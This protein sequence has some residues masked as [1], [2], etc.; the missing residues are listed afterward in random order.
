MNVIKPARLRHGD[1]IGVVAPSG[2]V[3][4]ERIDRALGRLRDRGFRTKTYGD[5]YRADG[6]L[7]GDD[8]IRAHELMEAFTDPETTAVWCAR[9]GYGVARIIDQIDFD[10]IRGHPKVFIGFSDISILHIAIAQQTGLCTFHAPNL[11]DG[12]GADD[13]MLPATE[14]ALWH[15]VMVRENAAEDVPYILTY[16]GLRSH[17]PGIATG[18]LT[19]GNLAVICG[20]MGTPF[21]IDARG[22]VLLLEDIDERL[23]RV[24]RYLAQLTLAGKLQ[25]AAAILLGDFTFHDRTPVE[26]DEQ[27]AKVFDRYFRDLGIPV[28]SGVSAGHIRENFALPMNALVEVDADQKLVRVR[29]RTVC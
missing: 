15:A 11:Q 25:S 10:V 19:G 17:S 6:H 29:E 4:R 5:I 20:L 1:T 16:V 27:I 21:E 23:Y 9:G 18:R 28:L 3:D 8:A 14:T 13:D 12:F 26:T 2:P 22:R 24:D 7:A